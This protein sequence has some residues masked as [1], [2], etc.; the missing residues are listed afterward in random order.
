MGNGLGGGWW[1]IFHPWR[2]LG[3]WAHGH[4]WRMLSDRCANNCWEWDNDVGYWWW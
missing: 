3:V 4:P 1:S 2:W